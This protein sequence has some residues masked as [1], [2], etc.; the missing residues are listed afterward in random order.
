LDPAPAQIIHRSRFKIVDASST[1]SP[2]KSVLYNLI[3]VVQSLMQ[4]LRN[5]R[6]VPTNEK[7]ELHS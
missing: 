3:Y 1:Q 6:L 5:E 4:I 2:L 7:N